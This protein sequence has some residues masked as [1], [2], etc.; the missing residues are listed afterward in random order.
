MITVQLNG[1]LRRA[2][3]DSGCSQTIIL[4]TL[5]R[6]RNQVVDVMAIDGR[7]VRS[8]GESICDITIRRSTIKVRCLLLPQL[9]SDIEVILGLDVI[10]KLGGVTID[11][12]GVR[13][14][15]EMAASGLAS[16]TTEICDQ[17]DDLKAVTAVVSHDI[18]IVDQDFRAVF[19]GIK[20]TVSWKWKSE[21]PKLRNT[22]ANYG[23]KAE[24]R[25]G[26]DAEITEWIA[27]GW[28]QS[29]DEADN[30]GILPL[31]AI[32]QA[33]KGKIRPVLDYR[34]LNKHVTSHTGQSDVCDESLRRWRRFGE[35]VTMLDLRKAYLQIHV[36][37]DLWEFQKVKFRGKLYCLTRL[38]F[39][40]NVAP[41]IMS[42]IV[43]RV[44][45]LRGDIK[46]A[47]DSYI[48]DII[49]NTEMVEISDVVA[50]LMRYGLEVK[51]PEKF[52]SSRVLGLQ[53]FK[54]ARGRHWRRGNEIPEVGPHETITRRELFSLCGQL[55]GHYP[56]AGW[57][58][59]ACSFVKRQSIGTMW[60]EAIGECATAI[61]IEI[62]DRV[63]KEDPVQGFWHVALTKNGIVWCDASNLAL[64]VCLEIEGDIVE[65]ASWLR[66]GDDVAHINVAEL[67]AVIKGINI[68][69]KWNLTTIT[70]RTDSATVQSWLGSLLTDSHRVRTHGSSEMLVRRR[71]QIIHELRQAYDLEITVEF[72]PTEKNKADVLTRVRKAWFA[73]AKQVS[74]SAL[75]VTD[76][77][78]RCHEAHHLGID[79]TLYFVKKLIPD[80]SREA[81]Q[82]VVS[83]CIKCRTID[84][85]PVR[86]E[87]G[88]LAVTANW[89]RLAM[90]VT[91]YGSKRYL[92]CVDCG[93]SRFAIW[94]EIPNEDAET[95][96]RVCQQ[97]FREH[98]PPFQLLMDNGT[99]FKS[100]QLEMLCLGWGVER[101]FRCA[102]RPSGNGIVER[103]H[104]TVKR[105]AART[106][107]DPLDMVYWYNMSCST[108]EK[109]PSQEL[110][111][112]EWKDKQPVDCHIDQPNVQYVTGDK[113][114]CKPP[115]ARCTSVWTPGTVTDVYSSTNIE[116]DGTP[117]H[118]ADIRPAEIS[119]PEQNE[120]NNETG[121]HVSTERPRRIRHLPTHM[122]DYVLD[123]FEI[124]GECDNK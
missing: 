124:T 32:D 108:K 17:G 10:M 6:G 72:V 23:I 22:C 85:A 96:T 18:E 52:D 60:D 59:I 80:V 66:K 29:Y 53:I 101:M 104:R 91:H 47:T 88:E 115:K 83:N 118:V 39:G 34:E 93:P 14:G 26:F 89:N 99:S 87:R 98:G 50:H 102:Y 107:G 57:L 28:L 43:H 62:V 69:I 122:N 46:E 119:N 11:V 84:P 79:R 63:K 82:S 2:M 55:V 13:F 120:E 105:M 103:N 7:L 38:G 92:T 36:Q 33:N 21:P 45:C 114:Y 4:Q 58:R 94:R 112:Y 31:M 73:R 30:D 24:L 9:V 1:V 76:R 42:A 12:H 111:T 44:L 81:V 68:A 113:V 41:K 40:L 27:N 25:G 100:R 61:L 48:D 8:G 70:V 15:C 106:G 86:W 78:R 123:D 74:C 109:A 20:W 71:L 51:V 19:D 110:F 54:D 5:A 90:D 116:V 49:V 16:K 75:T 77:I 56:V 37:S 35:N 64:G 67:D 121:V 97:I 117:R 65:D 95:V 3:V